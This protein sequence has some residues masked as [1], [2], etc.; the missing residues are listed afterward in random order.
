MYSDHAPGLVASKYDLRNSPADAKA[1]E[2][3]NANPTLG[4]AL[5]FISQRQANSVIGGRR[6]ETNFVKSQLAR[7]DILK[8]G[9][10]FHS[11]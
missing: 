7:G 9:E 8:L 11:R 4:R 1:R 5:Q 3:S 6:L 2:T 10:T